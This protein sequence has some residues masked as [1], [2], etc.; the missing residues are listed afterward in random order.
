MWHKD[1][2]HQNKLKLVLAGHTQYN[3]VF[4]CPHPINSN[5]PPLTTTC[6]TTS[7]DMRGWTDALALINPTVTA[8]WGIQNDQ[9]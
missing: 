8:N 9:T 5:T 7:S 1:L 3:P 2:V 6:I 4:V